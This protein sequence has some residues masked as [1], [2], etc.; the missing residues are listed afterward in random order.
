MVGLAQPNFAPNSG[1][2]GNPISEATDIRSK[3]KN[4][5]IVRVLLVA[6]LLLLAVGFVAPLINAAGFS[7]SIRNALQ[8][9]LG[10][11]V[12]FEKAHF[13]IF[14]GP[15]FSLEKV[16]ISE[17]PHYGIEPFA[18]V[19]TLEARLRLDKLLQGC[20]QFS[21][22]RLVDPSLNLVKRSDG[23][24][25]VVELI[26][27]LSAP[28]QAPLNLFPFFEVAD[29]RVDFKLGTRKT[30]LY[31]SE[32]DLS[33]YPE[34]SGKVYIRFSGSPAR[35]DRAGM[36]FGHFRGDVNWFLNSSSAN[37]NQVQ[38]EVDLDPSNLSELTTLIEGHDIGVHGTVS[39]QLRFEGPA[40]GLKLAGQLRL[41]DVHRW[42]LL[43]S[44]GEDWAVRF[45]GDLDLLAHRFDIRTL[46]ARSGQFTPVTMHLRVDNF[47]TKPSSSVI[48]ELHD[49]PVQDLLPLAVRMGV[50]LPKG[51]ALHGT[52]NGVIG[53]SNNVGWRGGLTASNAEAVLEGAPTLRAAAASF[54]VSGDRLFCSPTI[55]EAGGGGTLKMSGDYSFS[56]QQTRVSLNAVDVPLAS[57][58]PLANSWLSGPVALSAMTVGDLTG[59]L[60]YTRSPS[61]LNAA[62]N[63]LPPQWSGQ[64]DLSNGTI[65]VP[66]LA[67]PLKSAQGKATFNNSSF[68]FTHLSASLGDRVLRASYRYSLLAKH[69]EH[70]RVDFPVAE[71]SDLE[72]A[73]ASGDRDESLWVRLRLFRRSSPAWLSARN[74]D[75]ELRVDRLLADGKPLGALTSRFLWQGAHLE[76][77]DVGLKLPQGEL[78]AHGTVDLASFVPH[79]HFSAT[80]SNY[81]WAN[82]VLNAQGQFSSTGAGKDLLRNLTAQGSFDG[83]DLALSSN[84]KFQ[85]VSGL[86][87]I[88]FSDDWPD[89]RLSNIQA[90]R[91]GDDWSG[92]GSTQSDGKLIINLLHAGRQVRFVSSLDGETLPNPQSG[93]RDINADIRIARE[94]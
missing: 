69:A 61:A 52:L 73:L 48:A 54:I 88:S 55:V 24:W 92:D 90:M 91:D 22:L 30:T 12:A 29:G 33:I 59:Q 11:N 21:G 81:P 27:R 1:S 67:I 77:T 2:K 53:Y 26:Q 5:R 43:P 19:P 34:R 71:L 47:L 86:F 10:R 76:L 35:T 15:G 32:S 83:E 14:S 72:A 45:G 68:E 93:A 28:R 4:R 50:P 80:A 9:A 82:G 46:P 78:A 85:S 36:G 40:T 74:L 56:D 13:S 79:W 41:N 66:G 60:S 65:A 44:S 63:P 49:A 75:G 42:D 8:A 64:F 7:G 37:A 20:I 62:G 58:K 94:R 39:A 57:L 70:V 18:Y 31:I 25:N 38:A 16:T 6:A 84:D 89:L 17:D 87:E 3:P 23:N 51:T